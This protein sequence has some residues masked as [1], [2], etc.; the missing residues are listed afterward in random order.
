LDLVERF[1]EIDDCT[2]RIVGIG[3]N[4]LVVENLLVV[5]SLVD[6]EK[7]KDFEKENDLVNQNFGLP[8]LD[9]QDG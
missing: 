4:L 2:S 3:Y 6:F 9:N 8:G 5:D 1:F 7:G